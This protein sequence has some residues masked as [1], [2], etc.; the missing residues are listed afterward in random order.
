MAYTIERVPVWATEIMDEP[1]AVAAKLQE[2]TDAGADLDFLI[3]R[4]DHLGGGVLFLTPLKGAKQSRVAK[5]LKLKQV[6][7]LHSL[8]V[9]G[10]DKHGLGAAITAAIADAGINMRGISAAALGR[11]TVFNLSFDNRTD[12]TKAIRVLK[13]VLKIK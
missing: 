2:L 10:P 6:S 1:G 3:A 11:R 7:S 12:T 4:R 5:K 13:K 9:A 8:R